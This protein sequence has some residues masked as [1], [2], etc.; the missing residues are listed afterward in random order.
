MPTKDEIL[1]DIRRVARER[2][3]RVGLVSF[4]KATRIPKKQVVGKHWATW[5]KALADAGLATSSFSRPRTDEN[6]VVEAVARLIQRLKK[7]PTENEFSLE[8]RCVSTFPSLKVIR[9]LRKSGRLPRMLVAHCANRPDLSDVAKIAAHQA[10]F[11]LSN[12]SATRNASVH[13]Y[14]YMMRSGR[15]YMVDHIMFSAHRYRAARSDLSESRKLVHSI[16]TDDPRGIEAYWRR[17]F[18]SKRV[19]SSELFALDV[20]DVAA[21]KLRKYQ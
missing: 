11:G 5:N 4:L 17:R 7:W 2:G 9:R 13:G 1:S 19:R 20:D 8:R 3:G 12:V 14:V 21:F 6:V 10:T 16:E 15:H 18:E